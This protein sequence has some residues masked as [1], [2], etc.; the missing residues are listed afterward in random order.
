[1][2]NNNKDDTV[3]LPLKSVNFSKDSP[4]VEISSKQ[5]QTQINNVVPPVKPKE[6][7]N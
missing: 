3:T 7:K 5:T 4:I 2:G 1:M 6:N